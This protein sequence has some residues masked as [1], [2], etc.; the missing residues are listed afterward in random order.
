MNRL[1]SLIGSCDLQDVASLRRL[2]DND[3][4]N[5][6][7]FED[8]E[9][10]CGETHKT[11]PEIVRF[12]LKFP[13]EI[14]GLEDIRVS[15]HGIAVSDFCLREFGLHLMEIDLERTH[16][17]G[18]E[19]FTGKFYIHMPTPKMIARNSAFITQG[20]LHIA[21]RVRF[22]VHMME[23]RNVV[24]GRNSVRLIR[25]ELGRAIRNFIAGFDI[26]RCNEYI[27]VQKRQKELRE[28]LVERGLVSFI[29]NG[30]ILPRSKSTELP[31]E[32]AVPF[33]SP[34]ED[35]IEVEFSDGEVLKGMGI[36]N[37]VTVI[38]GGGYS[39]KST[40]MDA[41][42]AGIYNHIPGDGREYC[43]TNK[44]SVKICAEDGRPVTS[45]NITPF[46]KNVTNI[47]T[48]YFTTSHASGS[49]SQAANIIE[50][51]TFG[52]EVLLIDEDKTATNFM[53]RDA[54]MKKIIQKDPIIPFTDRVRQLYRE[55]GIS[56]IL[57]IGGSS[58]YMDIA[59]N[60]YFMN[61]YTIENYNKKAELHRMY[62]YDYYEVGDDN[63]TKW[64]DKREIIS[65][66]F[67]SYKRLV[68]DKR[69]KERIE[70]EGKRILSIG[71]EEISISYIESIISTQQAT[72]IAFIIRAM[73]IKNADQ[74]F[75]LMEHID[76]IY[77]SINENGLDSVYSTYFNV[78]RDME[79]PNKIDVLSVISRMRSVEYKK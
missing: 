40:L 20:K 10:C 28:M 46:I 4:G 32:N 70:V 62:T 56:T 21:L 61:N 36:K 79:I 23:K 16:Q 74:S 68:D 29:A 72:A 2:Y 8:I 41:M 22:P 73:A 57:I 18:K 58:E 67:S 78:D 55:T 44:N 54:R 66:T 71:D 34:D 76:R 38:T 65:S 31:L 17:T 39:G 6:Y 45:L 60:I 19:R 77:S 51:I 15:E 7:Y 64:K 42:F 11:T 69:I 27:R 48:E 37:G 5:T 52:G 49:T 30:S 9:L 63:E 33:V 53:I 47:D 26:N 59:D 25:K 35:E 24:Q 43:V 14:L 13:L 75:N 3:G 50:A 1:V 12:T